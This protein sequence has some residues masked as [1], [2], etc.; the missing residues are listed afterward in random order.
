MANDLCA[1]IRQWQPV[2]PPDAVVTTPPQGA[3]EGQPY[4]AGFLARAV[5]QVLNLDYQ[6]TLARTDKKRWHGRHYALGQDAFRVTCAPPAMTLVIDDLMT[7]GT[8]MRLSLE[9][10]RAAG[11]RAY[12]FAWCGND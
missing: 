12:G 7:S 6:T 4:A 9:A 3:S 8:T 11:V 1:V 2:L 10:L 5:A